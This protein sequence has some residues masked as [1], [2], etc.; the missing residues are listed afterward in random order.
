MKK[1][2]QKVLTLRAFWDL[3]K[4]MLHVIRVSGTVV[5]SPTNTKIA[6]LHVHKPKNPGSGNRVSDFRVS[7]GPPV[8]EK[9]GFTVIF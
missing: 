1:E 5:K 8:S 7:W 2:I 9:F 4:T 3:E 6:H